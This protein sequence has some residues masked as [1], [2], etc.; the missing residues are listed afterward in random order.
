MER[1]SP[2]S[3]VQAQRIQAVLDIRARLEA[4]TPHD[5]LAIALMVSTKLVEELVIL[6]DGK[7]TKGRL[8]KAVKE[9]FSKMLVKH[10]VAGHQPAPDND[11]TNSEGQE[12]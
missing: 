6:S 5:R 10:V 12:E 9:D 8:I 7:T 11:E 4:F 2:I 3:P 1:K